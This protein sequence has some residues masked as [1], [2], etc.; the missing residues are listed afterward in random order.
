MYRIK[1]KNSIRYGIFFNNFPD[2]IKLYIRN[3]FKN[4]YFSIV[5][6]LQSAF[7]NSPFR[8]TEGNYILLL[9]LLFA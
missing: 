6:G 5:S 8:T 9:K 4:Y 1:N 3:A 7:Q 2:V